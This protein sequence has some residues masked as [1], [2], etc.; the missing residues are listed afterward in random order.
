MPY[1]RETAGKG[2]RPRLSMWTVLQ[3]SAVIR[4]E[5]QAGGPRTPQE[6]SRHACWRDRRVFSGSLVRPT[7]IKEH[8][9][10]LS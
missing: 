1:V 4:F 9:Y 10:G 2:G 5:L 3:L 8:V 6:W 7:I